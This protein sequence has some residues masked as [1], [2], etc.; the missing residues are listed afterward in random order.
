MKI[1]FA[2]DVSFNYFGNEYP[3]DSAADTAM[4]EARECFLN[5]DFSVINF[6]ST[7]GL[8]EDL[9]PIKKDGPTRSRTLRL[10]NISSALPPAPRAL[11]ITT[12][13]TTVQSLFWIR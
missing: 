4:A 13:A 8:R 7:F 1:V 2:S 9:V 5:A 3:G 10:P 12:Q 11:P 6:E